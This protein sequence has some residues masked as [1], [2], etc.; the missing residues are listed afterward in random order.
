MELFSEEEHG[1]PHVDGQPFG[2]RVDPR[3]VARLSHSADAAPLWARNFATAPTFVV[4]SVRPQRA[5]LP[6]AAGA[7]DA[8]A[9][10][11]AADAA[12]QPHQMSALAET[13]MRNVPQRSAGGGGGG[14]CGGGGSPVIVGSLDGSLYA[15]PVV[16]PHAAGALAP[17]GG[18][19]WGDGGDWDGEWDASAAT[20]VEDVYAG[21]RE[22]VAVQAAE[23]GVQAMDDLMCPL[24]AP[25]SP[26]RT[27]TFGLQHL[28]PAQMGVACEQLW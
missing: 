16:R 19:A 6:A 12:L 27:S 28:V 9:D 20:G 25:H 4:A 23:E 7:A 14:R 18:V 24:G 1:F 8:A 15:L 11:A 5:R 10:A 13:A 21:R 2:L 17:V 3:S 22:V 26:L